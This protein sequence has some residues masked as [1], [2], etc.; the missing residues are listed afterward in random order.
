M[1]RTF[2]RISAAVAAAVLLS[3][4]QGCQG[5]SSRVSANEAFALSASALSGRESYGFSGHV[6]LYDPEGR[7]GTRSAYEGQV[8][9]H[10]NLKINWTGEGPEAASEEEASRGNAYRPLKLLEAMGSRTAAMAYE[11]FPAADKPVKIKIKLDEAAAKARIA[12]GLREEM[13]RLKADAAEWPGV[14][15]GKGEKLL[16]DA[17]RRLEAAL[18]TLRVET[19]VRWTADPND[20]FP[21]RMEEETVLNYSWEGNAYREKRVSVTDFLA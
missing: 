11:E 20:W 17:E 12:D 6:V 8:R 1:R 15:S 19:T 5:A 9:D 18:A 3:A 7:P 4:L 14:R 2:F 10:G 21:R 13:S 16:S